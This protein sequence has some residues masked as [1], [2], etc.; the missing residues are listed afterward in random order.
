LWLILRELKEMMDKRGI[1]VARSTIHRWAVHFSPLLMERL[2]RRKRAVTGKWHSDETCSKSG[3]NR[4][5]F[6]AP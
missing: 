2:N 3:A 1:S 6:I 5:I 4:C